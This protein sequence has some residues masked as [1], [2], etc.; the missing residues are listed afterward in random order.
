MDE[1]NFALGW[2][3]DLP[4][5]RDHKF[6][7]PVIPV[8]I[9]PTH[10]VAF[11]LP[12]IYDQGPLGSCTANASGAALAY[13]LTRQHLA[14]ITPARLFIYYN[15][16]M[17][18]RTVA[19]DAGA[20]IRNSI[21]SLKLYGACPEGDYPYDVGKFR[22]RPL[23]SVYVEAKEH[24]ITAY[25][26]LERSLL[27]FK[28]ALLSEIPIVI[29]FS[30]YESFYGPWLKVAPIP[31]P[32]DSLVGGHA[33]LIVGYDDTKQAFLVRNSWGKTWKGDGYFYL[34]YVYITNPQLSQDFWTILSV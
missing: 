7:A 18:E 33:V 13:T 15:T 27:L 3:P 25:Q 5:A 9:P 34:P 20:T 19:Y 17:I 22:D 8:V 26:R 6:S 32:K 1:K 14:P 29:G 4:D 30:V 31:A 28:T 10:N 2:I 16:R 12:E 23:G 11:Q 21:K 24:V